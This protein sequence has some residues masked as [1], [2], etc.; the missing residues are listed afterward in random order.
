MTR[1][2]T[3]TTSHKDKV[4]VST[5]RRIT[6]WT[7][8]VYFHAVWR[9]NKIM[10]TTITA[11]TQLELA[12]KIKN[13]IAEWT[14]KE[15]ELRRIAEDAENAGDYIEHAVFHVQAVMIRGAIN[16]LSNIT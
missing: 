2:E 3:P 13:L 7:A 8:A 6:C 5:S 1:A 10:E 12:A 15:R 9:H 11:T 4:A 14:T 16:D